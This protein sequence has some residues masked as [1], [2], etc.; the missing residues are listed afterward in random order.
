VRDDT[1]T[2][3]VRLGDRLVR[4]IQTV[5]GVT[6]ATQIVIPPMLGEGVWQTRVQRDGQTDAEAEKNPNIDM[7]FCGPDYF[8]VFGVP[9]LRGRAFTE[10]D[11]PGSPPVTIVSEDVAR[12]LWPGE[13]PLGKRIRMFFEKNPRTVVGI[14]HD[15]HL[16]TL[17][18]ASPTIYVPVR[19]GTWQGSIAIRSTTPLPMLIP[20]LRAAGTDV[21]P[22]LELWNPRTMNEVLADPLAQPRVSALLMSSFGVVALVLAAIGLF[23]V[24]TSLVRY[25]T[26]EFGIRMALGATPGRVRADVMRHA[27]FVA[28]IGAGVGLIGALVG[29]RLLGSLLFEVSPTDPFALGGACVVLLSVAAAAAYLP[30]R[31]ATAIDPARALRAD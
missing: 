21:D 28:A 23:G 16:R 22:D 2:K 15:T 13:D 8:K 1:E 27:G 17:R 3:V 10:S 9:I 14:A 6:A 11:R 19:Q 30:A 20:S 4:R 24:M 31:R 29:S 18:A 25:Q 7:E 26:R 12:L 5:P